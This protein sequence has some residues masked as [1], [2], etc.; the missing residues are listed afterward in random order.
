MRFAKDFARTGITLVC[1]AAASTPARAQPTADADALDRMLESSAR[2]PVVL[3]LV[4]A[5]NAELREARDRAMAAEARVGAAARRPDPELKGELWGVPLARPLALRDSQTIML[6]LRQ[7]FPAWG[8]LDA[9]ERAARADAAVATE[10]IE[11]RRQEL[12]ATARRAFAAYER[13]DREARIHLEHAGLTSRIVEVAR[14]LYAVGR[15]TQQDLLDAEV[16]LS[17]LHLDVSGVEQQRRSAAALLNALMGRAPD[18]PIGPVPD[19]DAD[20]GPALDAGDEPAEAAEAR[21]DERRPELRAAEHAVARSAA[22]L[23]LAKREARLPTVMVGADYW[24]MPMFEIKHGYGAMVSMSLPWLN[25]GR[26]DEVIAA[27]RASGAERSAREA[28]RVAARYQL[29]DADSKVRAAREVL[30]LLHERVL[31]QARRSYEAAEAQYR[32]GK[33]GVAPVLAAA[34]SYLQVR[35]DELRALADLE[36]SR[37]DYARAAGLPATGLAAAPRAERGR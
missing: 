15:G 8:S 3:A 25:P 29:R 13:A 21:L 16:E 24:Y 6:G 19:A 18:A 9:R 31:A 30:T 12:A 37:A 33:G 20:A 32:A 14:A 22:A 1:V 34:R 5:R 28:Q 17:R 35:V 36:T 10:S 27:E 26:R 7:S 23:D 4:D 11:T 2:L